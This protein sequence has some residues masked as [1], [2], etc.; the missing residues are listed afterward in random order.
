ME[1]DINMPDQIFLLRRDINSNCELYATLF[2]SPSISPWVFIINYGTRDPAVA[3][4][5]SN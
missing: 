2:T 5:S 4:L 1:L 3:R